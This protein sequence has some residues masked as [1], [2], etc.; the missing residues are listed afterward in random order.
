[1]LNRT[2]LTT[3]VWLIALSGASA[4]VAVVATQGGDRRITGTIVICLALIKARAILSHYLGLAQAPGWLS[5][6]VWMI[7]AFGILIIGLY[8]IPGAF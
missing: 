8:L 2:L 7:G 4:L 3:W 5:G 6:F 1:M